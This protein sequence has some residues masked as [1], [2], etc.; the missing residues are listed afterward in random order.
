MN[1]L[2]KKTIWFCLFST[3]LIFFNSYM[4]E[5][6]SYDGYFSLKRLSICSMDLNCIK[7]SKIDNHIALQAK[8]YLPREPIKIS[9]I[10]ENRSIHA[11]TLRYYLFPHKVSNKPDYYLDYSRQ[12]TI[13]ELEKYNSVELQRGAL[14]Y[15]KKELLRDTTKVVEVSSAK[16]LSIFVFGL[17][18]LWIL[19][20][21]LLFCVLKRETSDIGK[22][23]GH[24]LMLG[25]LIM[26]SCVWALMLFGFKLSL[27]LI[28]FVATFMMIVSCFFQKGFNLF[29]KKTV[30]KEK[31]STYYLKGSIF[32]LVP[33]VVWMLNYWIIIIGNPVINWDALSHWLLK[34][35]VLYESRVLDFE[36]THHNQYPILWPISISMFYVVIGSMAEQF[37]RMWVFLLLIVFINNFYSI[38]KIVG[39]S[40]RL[41][42]LIIFLWFIAFH[43]YS[44]IGAVAQ[45]MLL[46]FLSSSILFL[47]LWHKEK[48]MCYAV[49]SIVFVMG[50]ILTKYEGMIISL[51]IGLPLVI[52]ALLQ[53]DKQ[54][55]TLGVIFCLAGFLTLLWQSYINAAG[56]G[57]ANFHLQHGLSLSNLGL[58]CDGIVRRFFTQD[59]IVILGVLGLG[60][61]MNVYKYNYKN[62][63]LNHFIA[64]AVGLTLFSWFSFLALSKEDLMASFPD[65][66]LRLFIR[67]GFIWCIVLS[68][69]YQEQKTK[70]LE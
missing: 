33:L 7:G 40:F 35:N 39:V 4:I 49:L 65:V 46:A 34:A 3:L 30:I 67:A 14:L 20:R 59:N 68:I 55:A 43:H 69:M 61:F 2:S 31:S 1:I 44:F 38:L 29:P 11:I 64:I 45:N 58:L 23:W 5:N 10:P 36:Y 27:I 32:Y 48:K 26:S 21:R 62:F 25:V 17:L 56:F 63:L 28:V 37:V 16:V 12:H 13:D 52:G 6:I 51:F 50:V 41:S 42:C 47:C 18:C 66:T 54:G 22:M 8:E 60:Y 9:L 15:S 53:K 70:M 19:G 57:G 24:E